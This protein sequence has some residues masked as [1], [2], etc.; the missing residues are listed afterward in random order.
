MPETALIVLT[1]LP[2]RESAQQ[3]AEQM[4]RQNLAACVNILGEMT[5]IYR[6]NGEIARG[7]EHQLLIKTT[8]AGYPALQAWIREQHPYELPEILALPVAQGL[9]DYID[10]VTACIKN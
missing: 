3:F 4:I 5:S 2:D 10:W 1:T 9:P 7:T 8:Q 6:W